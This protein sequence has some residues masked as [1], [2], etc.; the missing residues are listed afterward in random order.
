PRKSAR[1]QF[2][3]HFG[4]VIG[5]NRRSRQRLFRRHSERGADQPRSDDG[6]ATNLKFLVRH[7]II[8]HVK[9]EL[10]GR[11]PVP[12]IR[13][14]S[15]HASQHLSVVSREPLLLPLHRWPTTLF[16][17]PRPVTSQPPRHRRF[18]PKRLLERARKFQSPLQ[19]A[20]R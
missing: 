4:L 16:R 13:A 20:E 1:A 17:S 6:N 3:Q 9:W 19:S 7:W 18:R 12:I 14:D 2:P 15:R 10:F 5:H 11:A 8:H